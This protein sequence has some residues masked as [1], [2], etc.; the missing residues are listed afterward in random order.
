[1]AHWLK[2]HRAEGFRPLQVFRE[3]LKKVFREYRFWHTCVYI[4]SA[5]VVKTSDQGH[6]RSGHQATSS[7][8]TSEKVWML[9]TATPNA[10][11]PWNFERLIS[12]PVSIKYI[13]R[14]FVIDDPRSGRFWDL[15]ITSTSMG[16]SKRHIFWKKTIRNTLKHRFAVRFDSLTQNIGTND[17]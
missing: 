3:C 7:D 2:P 13:S 14:N 16:E 6:S 1:M 11:S 15:S 8:L 10:R 9:V 12:L 17:P 5:H 4:F